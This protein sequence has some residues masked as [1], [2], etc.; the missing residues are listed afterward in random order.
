MLHKLGC[1]QQPEVKPSVVSDLDTIAQVYKNHIMHKLT[2]I[3]E[4]TI[5]KSEI[6]HW[7]Y[8]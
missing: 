5:M 4:S 7:N 1:G 2:R 8:K 6:V 3:T